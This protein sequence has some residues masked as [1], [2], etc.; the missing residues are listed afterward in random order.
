[1][2]TKILKGLKPQMGKPEL[3]DIKKINYILYKYYIIFK[4]NYINK[5]YKFYI[6]FNL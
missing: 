2:T 4:I 6:I 3:D 5:A 1:M